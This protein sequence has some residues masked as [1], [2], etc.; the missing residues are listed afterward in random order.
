M[1]RHQSGA[2][3]IDAVIFHHPFRI[4]FA[5]AG[6]RINTD[7]IDNSGGVD[8]SDHEVNI[9]IATGTLE[10]TGVLNRV[11]RDKLLKSMTDDIA[12]QI[13]QLASDPTI[14]ALAIKA[15]GDDL[16]QARSIPI[17][18]YRPVWRL[19][20]A[21]VSRAHGD[22][23]SMRIRPSQSTVMKANR[24]STAVFVTVRSRP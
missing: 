9:K 4:E 24:G 14:A 1:F 18:V 22:D 6:G 5:Q 17:P 7:A 2:N 19:V 20:G 11:K 16:A 23:G 13:A 3:G 21:S 15:L 10:R 12:A 8:T